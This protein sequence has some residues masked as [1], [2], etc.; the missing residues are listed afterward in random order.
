MSSGLAADATLSV[1]AYM[2]CS[3]LAL[4]SNKVTIHHFPAPASIFVL[5]IAVSVLAVQAFARMR[6]I[7]ADRLTWENV[8]RFIPYICSFVISLYSNGRA[9]AAANVET[10]IVFRSCSPLCVCILDWL[11]LGRELPSLRS[12]ASLVGVL[13]GAVGYVLSDSEFAL[14]GISAYF[15]V[16]VNL[17]G[18][19]FE[20]TYGKKLISNVKFESPVWGA[21]LYTNIL[22]WTPMVFIAAS[23]NEMQRLNLEEVSAHGYIW[24]LTS[25]A[26]GLGIS[27]SGWNCRSRISATYYTLVGVVCKFISV[28]LNM[29]LWDKHATPTGLMMLSV[30][31]VASSLYQQAPMR[32]TS[33]D[34]KQA[35]HPAVEAELKEIIGGAEGSSEED[36]TAAACPGSPRALCE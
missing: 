5:Q 29:M 3:S 15:W 21:T 24:L 10:V 22:A 18:I 1:L 9:L 33:E 32:A 20:M 13:C 31:L 36:E 17:S 4:V 7:E 16:C 28:I 8:R 12:L 11:F 34:D 30:C 23:T 35:E 27:W 2:T 6:W 25:C 19:V 14:R 26:I